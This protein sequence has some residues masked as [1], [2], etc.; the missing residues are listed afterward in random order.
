MN[1][2]LADQLGW[3]IT[4][5]D[6]LNDLNKEL[7]FVAGRYEGSIDE[8]K[9]YGY[10]KEMLPSLEALCSEFEDSVESIVQYI[11]SEHISYVHNRS[12][13]IQGQLAAF[14]G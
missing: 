2:G 7:K 8:L 10:M 3:C 9:S 5:Q 1:Q 11:E 6:Y 14:G 13:T 12:Q 4:T